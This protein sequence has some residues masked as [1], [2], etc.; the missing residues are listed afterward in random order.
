MTKYIFKILFAVLISIL[1]PT[2]NFA[3]TKALDFEAELRSLEGPEKTQEEENAEILVEKMSA[4]N[5]PSRENELVEDSVS[6][7]KSVPLRNKEA[8]KSEAIYQELNSAK[9]TR[10]IPSR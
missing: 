4:Q 10:R 1:I 9:K 5:N 6:D 2:V 3:D 8:S 7:Q